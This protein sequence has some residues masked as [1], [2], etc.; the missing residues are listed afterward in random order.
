ML[1]NHSTHRVTVSTQRI[2]DPDHCDDRSP[3]LVSIDSVDHFFWADPDCRSRLLQHR[4]AD[5]GFGNLV[6]VGVKK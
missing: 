3:W 2:Y 1:G 6:L 5:D 4:A